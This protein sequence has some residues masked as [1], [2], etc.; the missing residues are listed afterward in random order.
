MQNIFVKKAEKERDIFK[1]EEALFSA[2]KFGEVPNYGVNY[3]RFI[4]V[5][6]NSCAGLST[7]SMS[8]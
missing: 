8:P 3:K 4:S 2:V 5:F 1:P 7:E 6:V